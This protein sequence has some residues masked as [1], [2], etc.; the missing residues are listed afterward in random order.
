M[1]IHLNTNIVC[2]T[3]SIEY[4]ILFVRS[5]PGDVSINMGP[6]RVLCQYHSTP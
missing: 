3:G 2:W 1:Y 4:T 5:H 6:Q